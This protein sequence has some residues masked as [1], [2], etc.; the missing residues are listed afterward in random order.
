MF[1]SVIMMRVQAN[2]VPSQRFYEYREKKIQVNFFILCIS[3][4]N[5]SFEVIKI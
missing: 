4:A 1:P 5:T 3:L 2:N